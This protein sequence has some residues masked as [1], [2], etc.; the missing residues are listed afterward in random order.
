MK[1]AKKFL[2]LMLSAMAVVTVAGTGLTQMTSI[3]TV[4]AEEDIAEVTGDISVDETTFPDEN[5][6]TYI[7][8]NIDKDGNGVLSEEE[9]SEC[10]EIDNLYD[11]GSIYSMKGIEIFYNLEKLDC[12]QNNIKTLDVSQNTALT[13]LNCSD[14]GISSIDISKNTALTYLSCGENSIT[15]IDVSNNTALKTLIVAMNNL[16]A[17]DVSNNTAL[18]ELNCVNNKLKVIDVSNNTALTDFNCGNNRLSSIDTSKNTEL[19]SLYCYSNNLTALDISKNYE[20]RNVDCENNFITS[21]DITNN[22]KLVSYNCD[23]SVEIIGTLV[24][25]IEINSTNFYDDAFREYVKEYIDLDGDGMLTDDEI[26]SC[27]KISCNGM[28]IWSLDGIEIFY[29][30]EELDCSDNHY[31]ENL[32]GISK[33]TK[34]KVLN[35]SGNRL[36]QLN[37]NSN[38]E[39]ETV[40]C[41]NNKITT[42]YTRYNKNL[43]NFYYDDGVEIAVPGIEDSVSEAEQLDPYTTYTCSVSDASKKITASAVFQGYTN[44]YEGTLYAIDIPANKSVTITITDNSM[45]CAYFYR[46]DSSKGLTEAISS[47][48]EYCP[49]ET[50]QKNTSTETVT[51]YIFLVY[52]SVSIRYDYGLTAPVLGSLSNVSNGVKVSWNKVDGASG[53]YVYRHKAGKSWEKIGNV[54]GENTLTYVDTTVGSGIS[55][56]YTVRAYKKAANGNITAGEYDKTGKGIKALK[57]PTL[58]TPVNLSKG[59]QVKWTGSS[60]ANGYYVYR[61]VSGGK[62]TKIATVSGAKNLSYSDTTAEKG[63]T[64]VYTVRAYYGAYLSS[65]SSAGKSISVIGQPGLSTF[66]NVA[67]GIQVNWTQ[68]VGANG[69]YVYRKVSGGKWTRVGTIQGANTL[70]FVDKTAVAGTTYAYTVRAYKGAYVSAYNTSGKGVKCLK[71]PTVK[72]SAEKNKITVKWTKSAGAQGYYI[73]R[74]TVTGKW[75]V[76][77]TIKNGNTLSYVDKTAKSGVKYYYTIKAY[78]GSYTSPCSNAPL[79]SAK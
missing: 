48:E 65:F 9:I 56:A 4:Q 10:K 13:Y 74:K 47:F 28:S 68:S 18:E 34:L 73:Y 70:S 79:L 14:T 22:Q 11:Y 33:L 61:K 49:Y 12:G 31:I 53:Y 3:S 71:A 52:G 30:L 59:V 58:Y 24:Q 67:S 55:Y 77:A 43:V 8:K 35:C 54:T 36:S 40:D 60:G 37:I 6:R 39:L 69:Y 63:K 64:Y 72:L 20:L 16:S 5:F 21:L 42:I 76:V 78:Y 44:T 38:T 46:T 27:T 66:K 19:Y 23:D 25:K 15:S 41:R 62:W 26:S 2:A 7:E 32:T 75:T 50:V 29:N 17:L 51:Y 57:Q 1:Q 45:W